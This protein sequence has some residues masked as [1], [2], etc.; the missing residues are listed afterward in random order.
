MKQVTIGSVDGQTPSDH[1]GTADPLN[2][3]HLPTPPW[4]PVMEMAGNRVP[5]AVGQS[6]VALLPG[7]EVPRVNGA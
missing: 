1:N 2:R 3:L 4:C 7:L 5:G 6:C